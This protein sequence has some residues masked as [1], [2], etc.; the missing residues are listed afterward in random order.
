[1][2]KYLDFSEI[3]SLQIEPTSKCNLLCPQCERVVNGGVNPFLPLTELTPEDYDRIF[4]EDLTA[5][6]KS[7]IFNGSYGDPA[8]SQYLNYAI[9]TLLQKKVKGHHPVHQ[10]K[11]KNPCLVE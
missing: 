3:R 9:N 11:F 1:M 7:V 2:G 4:T 10:W 6:L 5:Q 8:A